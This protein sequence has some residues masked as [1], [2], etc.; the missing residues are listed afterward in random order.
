M[1]LPLA[2]AMTTADLAVT[3]YEISPQRVASLNEWGA[4]TLAMSAMLGSSRC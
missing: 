2:Q 3:G 4:D 1:G